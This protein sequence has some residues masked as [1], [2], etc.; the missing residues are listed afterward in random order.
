[1]AGAGA[2]ARSHGAAGAGSAAQ[3]RRARARA[4]RDG[5]WPFGASG[6]TTRGCDRERRSPR[7][8][9]RTS[10][11]STPLAA[12]L[13]LGELA[14]ILRDFDATLSGGADL[15]VLDVDQDS[16]S[17]GPGA[18]F[19]AR[20]GGKTDGLRYVGDAARRGAVAVMVDAGA[21]VP[22]GL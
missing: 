19:A 22:A 5:N 2:R 12:G 21:D 17:V 1:R 9:L 3:G 6:A 15:S 11:V 13:T 7:D 14:A 18:L 4:A 20:H 16:R 10:D 8:G